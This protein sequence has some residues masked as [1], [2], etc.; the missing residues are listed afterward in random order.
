MSYGF[1]SPYQPPE[2]AMGG[3]P[4]AA[5]RVAGPAIA[6]MVNAGLGML[7]QL[8]SAAMNLF[9]GGLGL[10]NGGNEAVQLVVQGSMGLV[11]NCFALV[12]G[13]FIIFG[14]IKMK[15]ME[16]Y[17]LAMAATV[18]SMLPC[19]SPCCFLGL[20]L[21][22]WSLVVLMDENNKRAFRA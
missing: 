17:G 4:A 10:A 1:D 3:D 9:A 20:P 7:M 18:I 12:V 19:L 5:G 13:G 2:S 14:A 8:L 21:G 22:I 11:M 6:L 15:N 16:S